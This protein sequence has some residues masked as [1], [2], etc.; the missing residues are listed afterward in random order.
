MKLLNKSQLAFILDIKPE[1]ARAMMCVAWSK[2]KGI[3]NDA[4]WVGEIRAK[5]QSDF[6]TAMP[7]DMLSEHLNLPTLAQSVD[8]IENNYLNRPATKKWILF[9]C[10]EKQIA[11]MD[12]AEKPAPLKIPSALRSLLSLSVIEEIKKE[13]TARYPKRYIFSFGSGGEAKET[14]T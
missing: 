2:A 7:I 12:R 3:K 8:D 10:P 9:D 14:V 4:V 5:V 13:W 1:D 11:A 6:P